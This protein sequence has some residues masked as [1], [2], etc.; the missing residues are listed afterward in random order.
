MAAEEARNVEITP[1]E[2][3][4]YTRQEEFGIEPDHAD[5]LI[6]QEAG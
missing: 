4:S 5:R 2:A 6:E 1:A 3:A